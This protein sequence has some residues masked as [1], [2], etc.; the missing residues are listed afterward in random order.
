VNVKVVTLAG[1]K[2]YQYTRLSIDASRFI[3]KYSQE[4]KKDVTGPAVAGALRLARQR[5][6]ARDII[7][8]ERGPSHATDY[9]A[10]RSLELATDEVAP[11]GARPMWIRGR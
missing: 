6:R 7:A 5:A 11:G 4:F 8:I 2:A 10:R 9:P 1:R 3:R